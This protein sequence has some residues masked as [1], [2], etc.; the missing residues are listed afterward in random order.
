M[1]KC[2]FTEQDK[3]CISTPGAPICNACKFYYKNKNK[4]RRKK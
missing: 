4:K 3:V 2:Y 1:K